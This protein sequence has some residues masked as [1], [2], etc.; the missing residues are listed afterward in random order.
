MSDRETQERINNR[1]SGTDVEKLLD[2][3]RSF[4]TM[5][6]MLL[7]IRVAHGYFLQMS[8]SE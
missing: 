5:M 6:M 8:K 4:E 2:G 1:D 7:L 3:F